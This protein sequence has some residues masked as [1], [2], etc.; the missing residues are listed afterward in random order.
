MPV[1][2]YDRKK[3]V[4]RNLVLLSIPAGIVLLGIGIAGLSGIMPWLNLACMN[5]ACTLAGV[6]LVA[7]VLW[8]W[9]APSSVRGVFRRT[10]KEVVGTVAGFSREERHGHYGPEY[11]YF[12]TV[13]FKA[14]D[15]KMGTRVIQLK[16]QVAHHVWK[17]MGKTVGIRYAAE[18]PRIALIEG[19]W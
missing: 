14:D 2:T 17:G 19:E 18:D 9:L 4:S 1:E 3:P 15:P 10:A 5:V 12:V 13:R 11:K 7:S 8:T 16:A 6:V